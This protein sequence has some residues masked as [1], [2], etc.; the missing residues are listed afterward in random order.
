MTPHRYTVEQPHRHG[1]DEY[2]YYDDLAIAK[3][4]CRMMAGAGGRWRVFDEEKGV[5]IFDCTLA[6]DNDE[7]VG[8]TSA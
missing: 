7:P 1:V 2:G 6:N 4:A 8:R 3:L 5:P